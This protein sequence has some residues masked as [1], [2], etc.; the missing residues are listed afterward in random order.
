MDGITFPAE[1]GRFADEAVA[2]GRYRSLGDLIAAGMGLLKRWEHARAALV[3][4][5]LAARRGG[6]SSLYLTG[7]DSL[8]G[9]EFRLARRE[10]ATA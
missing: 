8:V 7:D 1:L 10:A 6:E 9:V 2:A 4:S 5:V 3:A